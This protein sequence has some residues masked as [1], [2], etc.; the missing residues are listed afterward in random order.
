MR[1]YRITVLARFLDRLFN[2]DAKNIAGRLLLPLV[3]G[4][5]KEPLNR[6]RVSHK[7]PVSAID[8]EFRVPLV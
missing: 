7:P 5:H 4:T 8:S 3:L 2:I 6:I 1:V